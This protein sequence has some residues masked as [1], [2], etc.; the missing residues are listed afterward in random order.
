M[1][2]HFWKDIHYWDEAKGTSG[3]QR[4]LLI[5]KSIASKQGCEIGL[6]KGVLLSKLKFHQKD[7]AGKCVFGDTNAPLL[8]S[9][10]PSLMPMILNH[11][12]LCSAPLKSPPQFIFP[13]HII[14]ANQILSFN[15]SYYPVLY[16]LWVPFP[17]FFC[18]YMCQVKHNLKN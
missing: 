13:G 8:L 7:K 12:W 16:S 11:T 3:T 1:L 15:R 14:E 2:A 18:V 4:L 6:A 10:L 9:P 17:F 5:L